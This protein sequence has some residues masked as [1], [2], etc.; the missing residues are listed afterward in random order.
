VGDAHNSQQARLR[1][2]ARLYR[3]LAAV[4]LAATPVAL[5]PAGPAARL[6]RSG[7]PAASAGGSGSSSAVAAE[8]LRRLAQRMAM[9]AAGSCIAVHRE[10]RT[11]QNLEA[12][13]AAA[14][15]GGMSAIAIEDD[16]GEALLSKGDVRARLKVGAAGLDWTAHHPHPAWPD[17]LLAWA[18][19]LRGASLLLGWQSSL[20]CA[21]Y[22]PACACRS[23][24][25]SVWPPRQPVERAG[26]LGRPWSI[27]CR[28]SAAQARLDGCLL[29]PGAVLRLVY[30]LC[31]LGCLH[32]N[33]AS[34][35]TEKSNSLVHKISRLP[36]WPQGR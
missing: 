24:G 35:Q 31:R 29:R 36:Q 13:A 11:R 8:R 22:L 1:Y 5:A 17:L 32:A 21:S 18:A 23:A 12:A 30:V 27:C 10:F 15:G 33:D 6:Q 16:G 3:L 7:M 25:V 9:L 34:A 28:P 19:V 2:S 4:L 26:G 20:I 14:A